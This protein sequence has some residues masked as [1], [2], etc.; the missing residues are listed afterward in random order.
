MTSPNVSTE[1]LQT[2]HRIHRQLADLRERLERGP[3]QIRAGAAHVAHQQEQLAGAQAEAKSVLMAADAKQLQLKSGEVKIKD[4]QS[5]LNSASSNREYQVLKDHV[6]A[7]K[8]AG[9]V[10]DDEILE[11]WE[12][13]EQCKAK[14]AATEADIEKAKQKVEK[15]SEEVGRQTPLIQGDINRLESELTEH[16]AVMPG[17]ILELYSRVVRQRGEDALA[18]I[19]G[20]T[21]SGCHQ[22]T[23]L[24]VINE[25]MLDHPMFCKSCGRLLYMPEDAVD[26][27]R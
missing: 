6:A 13:L 7:E 19:E 22:R 27:G 18:A 9:S 10:L 24:N 17:D 11:A 8:M 2:I 26:G 20:E 12:K 3:R 1:S 4:L 23:P 14:I 15:V 16:E 5:K 21:C 25:I